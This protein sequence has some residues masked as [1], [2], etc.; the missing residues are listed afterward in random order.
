MYDP[1]LTMIAP[2]SVS[3]YHISSN[4]I[5]RKC[6]NRVREKKTSDS[7]LCRF[8]LHKSTGRKVS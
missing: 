5:L 6:Y 1:H 8:P 4:N 2:D 3:V 7:D